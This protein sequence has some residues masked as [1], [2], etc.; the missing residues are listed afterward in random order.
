MNARAVLL[1]A[2]EGAPCSRWD[3]TWYSTRP[4]SA[5]TAST[6]QGRQW[7]PLASLPLIQTRPRSAARQI[8]AMA[9]RETGAGAGFARGI[10]VCSIIG[11]PREALLFMV[12]SLQGSL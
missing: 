8:G 10:G 6:V 9:G 12:P 3:S 5:I 7:P 1:G 11:F 4:R 2:H